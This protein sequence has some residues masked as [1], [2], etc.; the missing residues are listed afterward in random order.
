[1]DDQE[2]DDRLHAHFA[3]AARAHPVPEFDT[4]FG[5][6]QPQARPTQRRRWVTAAAGALAASLVIAVVFER[7]E[8]STRSAEA[9]LMVQLTQSTRWTAPSDSW[10]AS[11]QTNDYLGLPQFDDMTFQMEEVKPWF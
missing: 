6:A 1:M 4:L 7:R 8:T 5:A 3:S 2:L 9:L 11:M 10:L